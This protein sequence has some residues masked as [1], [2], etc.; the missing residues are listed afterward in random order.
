LQ[1]ESELVKLPDNG[2]TM[3]QRRRKE[4]LDMEVGILNSN[5]NSLKTKLRDLNVLHKE[6]Y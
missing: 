2:K 6:N 3:A 5:I 4:D 1:V